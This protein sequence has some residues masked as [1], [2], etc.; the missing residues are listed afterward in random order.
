MRDYWKGKGDWTPVQFNRNGSDIL[1]LG[2]APSKADMEHV[3]LFSDAHGVAVVE[4]LESIGKSA[5]DVDW[6]TIIGCR[7]PDDDPKKFIAFLNKQNRARRKKSHPELNNPVKACAGHLANHIKRYRTVITLG[8]YAT[9]AVFASNVKLEAVRGGPTVVDGRRILPT[10]HPSQLVA[11]PKLTQVFRSDIGKAFRHHEDALRW[12]DPVVHYSP[13]LD[14]VVDFFDRAKQQGWML[15]YDVETDAKDCLTADLRCIGIGTDKEVLMLGFVSIDKVTRFYSQEDER[16]IKDILREVFDDDS[17]L[18]AGHNAG[19]FDRLVCEQHGLGTPKPLLDTILWH[20]LAASE[21]RHALGFIGSV[22]TDVP[23]W[24]ADHAGVT[25]KTDEEL[26]TYCATDVAVT[27][28]IVPFIKAQAAKREQSHLYPFDARVQDLC[29]GMRR[30][31][32]RVDEGRRFKHEQAE[33]VELAKWFRIIKDMFPNLNPRSNPQLRT[34]LF[35]QWMLPPHDYTET[36]EPTTGAAALRSYVANPLLDDDQRDFINA[37]RFYR[38]SSKLLS[39]Y[40]EPFSPHGGAVRDGFIYPDYNAHG[41]VTGR[42]SSSNPNFQNIPYKLRNI[43]IPPEGCVFVGAD[44]DQLELR[45][46]ASLAQTPHYIKAF[47]RQEIDP[48][49]LTADLMFGD[50]FWEARGAPDTKMGKGSGQFKQLRNL[51]K[52]ICFASLY[53][54]SPPKVRDLVAQAEDD[55]GNLLYAHYT[56]RQIRTLHRRWLGQAP[57]FRDW[58]ANTFNHYREHGYVQEIVMGRRR[59]FH[60][61][62]YN[63]TINF[64]V[65]AGAFAVVAKAM[66]ELV[67][68]HFPFDF[69]S[70]TGLVNNLH[71]AVL[72]SVPEREADY[73]KS[74]V[75][76]VMTTK[77]PGFPVTFTAEAEI[78][79]SWR[80]V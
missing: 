24:K 4:A 31:G 29:A 18:I 41:T 48:H 71:D 19:Y 50:K 45:Y 53:G 8:E 17:I 7:W 54:A 32:V 70:K 68:D 2:D 66:L 72:F 77:V 76:E 35:D 26:H 40:L 63:A 49:N 43:F 15:T 1:V 74:V 69:V 75:T 22:F 3:R 30:M 5:G 55:D 20:K 80:D 21:H 79:E 52:T 67:E 36:G 59:Y 33:R 6:G 14:V 62:D 57:E 38:R 23:A 61:E 44:Y 27:A 25:A 60:M 51:A 64:V 37:I 47:Q 65:Q 13:P 56:L 58:W 11:K 42:L 12:E 28:R 39:T 10:Y 34:I 73:A 9:K 46:A 78:G 16:Q